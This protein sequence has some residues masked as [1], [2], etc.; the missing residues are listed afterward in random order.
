MRADD[1]SDW[2]SVQGLSSNAIQSRLSLARRIEKAFQST[3]PDGLDEAFDAD[4]MVFILDRLVS[5]K[6]SPEKHEDEIGNVF[7]EG[8]NAKK[9]LPNY[10][11]ALRKYR[12]FRIEAP[13]DASDANQI[14]EYVLAEIVEPA[15]ASDEATVDF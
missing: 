9:L 4:D 10:L 6:N 7:T 15:R 1:F 2:L 3:Y 14:R 8:G 13:I 5:W 11:N 12:D